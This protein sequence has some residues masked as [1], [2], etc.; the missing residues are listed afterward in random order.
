MVSYLTLNSKPYLSSVLHFTG[1]E[2]QWINLRGIG[3]RF[4]IKNSIKKIFLTIVKHY[5][6][7]YNDQ[8]QEINLF[9]PQVSQVKKI[10]KEFQP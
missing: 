8:N 4:L 9:C 10:K 2:S 6:Y 7:S 5:A 1:A 3:G